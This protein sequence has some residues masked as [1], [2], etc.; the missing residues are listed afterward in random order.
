VWLK[1]DCP[2][3]GSPKALCRDFFAAVDPVLGTDYVG[4][5]KSSQLAMHDLLRAAAN[6]AAQHYLGLLVIDEIQ[7]LSTARS[8]GDDS[9]LNFLLRLENSIG[10]PVIRVGTYKAARLFADS[11][12]L[13]RRGLGQGDFVWDRM[14]HGSEGWATFWSGLWHYQYTRSR[15]AWDEQFDEVFYHHTQ[16][17]TDL[18][19]KL[20]AMAQIRAMEVGSECLTP[21]FV[22]RVA[23]HDFRTV[24]P[25]LEAVRSGSRGDLAHYED[26]LPP[27]TD[28]AYLVRQGMKFLEG[29]APPVQ[30][31]QPH[32]GEPGPLSAMPKDPAPAGGGRRRSGAGRQDKVRPEAATSTSRKAPS[33]TVVPGTGLPSFLG[34]EEPA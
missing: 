6:V 30:V 18:A 14:R 9:L 17:I 34:A 20:F 23:D 8:R 32:Q 21:E 2:L 1:V 27:A 15:A 4:A 24:Q 29:S 22:T 10:V 26:L 28:L 33:T 31:P 11:F 5:Y 25:A 3:D 7:N 12:Q 16:G 13:G 19:V